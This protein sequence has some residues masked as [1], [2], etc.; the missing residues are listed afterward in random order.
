MAAIVA[1]TLYL[2][3]GPLLGDRITDALADACIR[4]NNGVVYCFDPP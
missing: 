4:A 3:F 2:L 1:G